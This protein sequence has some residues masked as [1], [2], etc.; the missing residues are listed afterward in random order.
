ME[1]Y[2]ISWRNSSSIYP[3]NFETY[4]GEKKCKWLFNLQ[5]N[6][7]PL[8]YAKSWENEFVGLQVIIKYLAIVVTITLLNQHGNFN[9]NAYCKILLAVI[10]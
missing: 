7:C 8:K 10:F 4:H 9:I 1:N 5:A 3:G 6:V 2:N